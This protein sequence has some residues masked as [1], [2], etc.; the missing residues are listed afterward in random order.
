MRTSKT[1]SLKTSSLEQTFLNLW[2]ICADI[3]GKLP[4]PVREFLFNPERKWRYD[5][6]FEN[7]KLCIDL[8]GGMF[9][10]GRTGHSSST[11]IN[12]DILKGNSAV[13]LGYRVLRYSAKDLNERPRQVIEEIVSLLKKQQQP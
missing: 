11:G 2:K 3:T 13:L 10:K 4:E 6:A 12:R 9:L 7:E 8:E 5:F 1:A